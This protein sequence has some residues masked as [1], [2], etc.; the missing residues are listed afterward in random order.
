MI[1]NNHRIKMNILLIT[2]G[3][4][5]LLQS[6]CK[7]YRTKEFQKVEKRQLYADEKLLDIS[8]V[9]LYGTGGYSKAKATEMK[10]F[11]VR[12]AF[13]DE[14]HISNYFQSINSGITAD[15][16]Y[17]VDSVFVE[18]EDKIVRLMHAG[19]KTEFFKSNDELGAYSQIEIGNN[20]NI[21]YL[22]FNVSLKSKNIGEYTFHE[23]YRVKM[24][25]HES[26]YPFF[27]LD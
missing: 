16:S 24:K 17:Y 4:F 11:T 25:R 19:K 18:Y 1:N 10:D 13:W 14:D 8:V 12:F 15:S 5:I 3:I 21:I 26:A 7:V 23:H 22:I 6:S 2:M 27:L 20:I 9:A